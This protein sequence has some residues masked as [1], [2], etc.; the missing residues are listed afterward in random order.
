MG[1]PR[2]T[3]VQVI[4]LPQPAIAISAGQYLS[5]ALL[6]DGSVWFWGGQYYN[7][8]GIEQHLE[9]TPVR[10]SV[11][12]TA[13][14][15]SLNGFVTL[16]ADGR[17]Y[18]SNSGGAWE[19]STVWTGSA[20]S[21]IVSITAGSDHFLALKQDGTV[22]AW[23][24]N[25]Y[26]QLGLGLTG[27]WYWYAQQVNASGSVSGFQNFVSIACGWAYS[28]A[29]TADGKAWAWGANWDGELG[30]GT[31]VN[32]NQPVRVG[33]INTRPVLG[34]IA[35]QSVDEGILLTLAIAASDA[36]GDALRFSLEGTRQA[37]AIINDTTGE[38]QWTPNEFRDR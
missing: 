35:N 7:E 1:S 15:A 20:L 30:D 22:W 14:A 11:R 29:Y 27:G 36:E 28:L 16:G 34:P 2:F 4:G 21:P 9:P 3:P 24:D 6:D 31:T 8:G 17:A 10:S 18:W 5:I 38:F 26:G 25:S 12:M 19:P 37:G 23:G 32:K 13:I 33:A